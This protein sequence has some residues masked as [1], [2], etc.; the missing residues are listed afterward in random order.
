MKKFE[1]DKS[2][3]PPALVI[4][5]TVG[6]PVEAS[7]SVTLKGEI[8]TGAD[9]TVILLSLIE[10]LDLYPIG[11]LPV[12]SYDQKITLYKAYSVNLEILDQS[13]EEVWTIAVPRKDVLIGRDILQNFV[14]TYNGKKKFFKMKDP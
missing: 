13:Y 1:L 9:L 4:S 14:L 10:K 12:K 8:D 5:V 11:H 7:G 6:N 2:F 3:Q